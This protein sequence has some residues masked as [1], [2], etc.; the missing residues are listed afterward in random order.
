[1]PMTFWRAVLPVGERAIGII[2]VFYK[3]APRAGFIGCRCRRFPGAGWGFASPIGRTPCKATRYRRWRSAGR[4]DS[5]VKNSLPGSYR[6]EMQL[7]ES[8]NKHCGA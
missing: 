8:T 1:M 5:R 3:E 2:P 6:R 4:R 7:L